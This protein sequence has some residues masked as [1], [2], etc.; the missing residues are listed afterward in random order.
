MSIVES[1][2]RR[3]LLIAILLQRIMDEPELSA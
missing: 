3:E 2:S 1:T